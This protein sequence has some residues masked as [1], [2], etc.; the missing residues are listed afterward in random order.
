MFADQKTGKVFV[1]LNDAPTGGRLELANSEF[2]EFAEVLS[3]L[4]PVK[5]L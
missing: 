3:T 1:P 2:F 5:A 4:T